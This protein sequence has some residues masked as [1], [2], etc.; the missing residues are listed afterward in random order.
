MERAKEKVTLRSFVEFKRIVEDDDEVEKKKAR[1]WGVNKKM[2]RE[3]RVKAAWRYGAGPVRALAALRA[4]DQRER[5]KDKCRLCNVKDTE[6][7]VLNE[8]E[9][10]AEIR[11]KARRRL[12][13]VLGA[14]SEWLTMHAWLIADSSEL[15][16]LVG[17]KDLDAVDRETKRA[18]MEFDELLRGSRPDSK[19]RRLEREEQ[20]EDLEKAGITEEIVQEIER[21]IAEKERR[22]LLVEEEAWRTTAMVIESSSC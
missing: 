4:K 3:A 15:R 13:D 19:H 6:K 1:F 11:R 22:E 16:E 2:T 20:L 5:L 14:T 17:E 7:H 8:C 21:Q 9:L 10:Y 18:L 12:R